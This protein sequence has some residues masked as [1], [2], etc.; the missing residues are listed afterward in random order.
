M[1]LPTSPACVGE[2]SVGVRKLCWRLRAAGTDRLRL[3]FSSARTL[4][5]RGCPWRTRSGAVTSAV[6]GRSTLLSAECR[7]GLAGPAVFGLRS[8]VAAASGLAAALTLPRYIG[9]RLVVV[10][11][12]RRKGGPLGWFWPRISR[13]DKG[14][15]SNGTVGGLVGPG[16][17]VVKL[18]NSSNGW[19]ADA[20]PEPPDGGVPSSARAVTTVDALPVSELGRCVDWCGALDAL[21]SAVYA[22]PDLAFPW[23]AAYLYSARAILRSRGTPIPPS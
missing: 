3:F 23:S 4:A 12:R 8:C 18:G 16:S 20:T 6:R 9:I 21:R 22:S 14:S 13:R 1:A 19:S 17:G 15:G 10:C 11:A 5:G 7:G 2:R